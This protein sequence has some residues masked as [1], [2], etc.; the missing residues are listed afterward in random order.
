M[1][2][3]KRERSN[4]LEP[5]RV[6]KPKTRRDSYGERLIIH[7]KTSISDRNYFEE[8][9]QLML[10]KVELTIRDSNTGLFN[11]LIH[12]ITGYHE[13]CYEIQNSFYT[14]FALFKGIDPNCVRWYKDRFYVCTEK[15]GILM[16][17]ENFEKMGVFIRREF[18]GEATTMEFK[19]DIA[20]VAESRSIHRFTY[21][22]G[23]FIDTTDIPCDCMKHNDISEHCDNDGVLNDF[24]MKDDGSVIYT[25]A[26]DDVGF[27]ILTLKEPE[28]GSLPVRSYGMTFQFVN[29]YHSIGVE[30]SLDWITLY[31]DFVVT[32]YR[33]G[34]SLNVPFGRDDDGR[35]FGNFK[36]VE[37]AF[38]FDGELCVL[39]QS[40][41]TFYVINIQTGK[42]Q[43][44]AVFEDCESPIFFHKGIILV[45]NFRNNNLKLYRQIRDNREEIKSVVL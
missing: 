19:G 45:R 24:A 38:S 4:S 6:V 36:D 34:I 14:P 25:V 15:D 2:N 39:D 13:A 10:S 44:I 33:K 18:V 37:R 20:Y 27:L 43:I 8:E 29:R 28:T 23:K 41:N 21:P 7:E 11:D 9:K 22:D 1:N 3:N 32:G 12:M 40:D 35:T 5:H 30:M 17:S 26:D 31:K 42:R 16:Y